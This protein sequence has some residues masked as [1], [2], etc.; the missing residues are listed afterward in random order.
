M[1]IKELNV[2]EFG[3]LVG[4]RFDLSQGINIIEGDNEAGKSTLWLFIK[5]MLY[6]MPKKGN[7]ER[8]RA[9]NRMTHRAVGTMTLTVGGVDYRIERSFSENSRGKVS[10]LR[11]SDGEKVFTGEEPGEALLRVPKDIFENSVA[12]GQGSCSG[13]GGE[14]GAA[15]IRN[16]LSSAD[17]SVDVEK[18]QKKLGAIRVLYRHI[19]GKGGKLFELSGRIN[20]L[21]ERYSAAV[22]NRLKIAELEEK[23]RKNE[24]NIANS[25]Q[26]LE[27]ARSLVDNLGRRE[28]LQRFD[29]LYRNEE[30]LR[31]LIDQREALLDREKRDGYVPL[32]VDGAALTAAADGYDNAERKMAEAERAYQALGRAELTQNERSLAELGAL[33]E[34]EGGAEAL[35]SALKKRKTK[36]NTG[37]LLLGIGAAAILLTVWNPLALVGAPI[38]AVLVAVGIILAATAGRTSCGGVLGDLPKGENVEKYLRSCVEAQER[39]NDYKRGIADAEAS[40]RESQ[41][42]VDYFR[43]ELTRAMERV[44]AVAPVTSENARAEV[45]RIDAF[46][47]EYNGIGVRIDNLKGLISRE[48]ELLSPYDEAAIRESMKGV[49]IPDISIKTAE[50]KQRFYKEGLAV[51]KDKDATFKTELINLKARGED[52]EVLGDELEALRQEYA[53]SEKTYEAVLTAIE[54]VDAAAAALRGSMTPTI[55]RNATELILGLTDGKYREVNVGRDLDL[56]LIDGS[57]LSTS[58]VMMSGGMRDGAYLALRIALMRNLFEGELPPIMMDETLC[59]LDRTRTERALGMLDRISRDGSQILLFTC[60]TREREICA[61]LKID[62]NT[63]FMNEICD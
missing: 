51:L 63:V 56:T 40:V 11:L 17:E 16:I 30:A 58:S 12:I 22:A 14:K 21:E 15:A 10:T 6:G 18:I 33:I 23:L 44:R 60:H 4:R 61:E 3:G 31:E 9:I 43:V 37:V 8:E 45:R 53:A 54:G 41:G 52:P 35:L 62:T 7:P 13:L 32:A 59:Q 27:A 5:F 36:K 26:S 39:L 28:I 2:I 25:E 57:E 48:R 47:K 38:G 1:I 46:V 20:R 55:G 19:N 49:E 42:L 34:A 29:A 24:K 50:E